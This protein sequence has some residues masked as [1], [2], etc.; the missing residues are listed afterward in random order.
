MHVDLT[1]T[2]IRHNLHQFGWLVLIKLGSSWQ[3][4]KYPSNSNNNQTRGV[5]PIYIKSYLKAKEELWNLKYI[6][7]PCKN[8]IFK[9][10]SQRN[11]NPSRYYKLYN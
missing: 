2:F 1:T 10:S 9:K 7:A 5:S 6:F 8:L 3:T 11:Q 4:N